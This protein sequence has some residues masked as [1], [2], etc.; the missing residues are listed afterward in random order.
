MSELSSY[1]KE[2]NTAIKFLAKVY[3]DKKKNTLDEE[4][5]DRDVKR[6]RVLITVD[7]LYMIENCGPFFLSYASIIKE[8]KW[9]ELMRCDFVAEK[10]EYKKTRTSGMPSVSDMEKNISFIKDTFAACSG[11][12]RELVGESI[13]TM[14][15]AYCKY[16][17]FIKAKAERKLKKKEDKAQ[18][19]LQEKEEDAQTKLQE[20]EEKLK[21]KEAKA[22][23][24]LQEKEEKLK[25]K[26]E[27]KLKK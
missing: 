19:R 24:R 10:E 5:A 26:E 15:S 4:S 1:G 12:E 9:D 7:P 3:A 22:Q 21:K 18:L 20:K 8:H 11:K 23:L 25:K 17:I 14:L 16:A 6:L 13:E 2:F 27:K